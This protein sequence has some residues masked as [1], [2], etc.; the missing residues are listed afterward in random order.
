LT[1]ASILLTHLD[2]PN[3]ASK[4]DPELSIQITLQKIDY[5]QRLGSFDVALNTIED[6]AEKLKDEEAD[7]YQRIHVMILKA[8]LFNRIGKPEKGFTV[9]M[10]AANA[11]WQAKILPALWEAWGTVANILGS[12]GEYDT[13]R[14]ILDAIIPQVSG[15]HLHVN[16]MANATL[17]QALGFDDIDL[18]AQLYMWQ[19]D[20]YMG[21]AG[22]KQDNPR[23]LTSLV[24]RA[25]TYLDRASRCKSLE[26]MFEESP[27]KDC[28][29][30][31]S[32]LRL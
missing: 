28:D 9:A 16:N 21:L 11:A 14:T 23:L 7:I 5:L 29:T 25:E 31:I 4:L 3:S 15:V 2:S 17:T 26:M 1:A 20:A 19:A 6:L 22:A 18:C 8:L 32:P 10:H 30:D 27:D 13:Q 24:S 12:L